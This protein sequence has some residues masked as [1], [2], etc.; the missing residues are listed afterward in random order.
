MKFYKLAPF[1]LAMIAAMAIA[2]QGAHKPAMP[3][4]MDMAACKKM[5]AESQKVQATTTAQQT[6][7][8]HLLTMMKGAGRNKLAAVED[9]VKELADQQLN[10][11]HTVNVFHDRMMTHMVDHMQGQTMGACP[12]MKGMAAKPAPKKGK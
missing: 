5:M 7:L 9:V 6:R 8:R 4:T 12:M 1:G 2:G 10:M 3:G 11:T